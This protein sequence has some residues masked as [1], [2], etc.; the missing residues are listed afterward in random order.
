MSSPSSPQPE[1]SNHLNRVD[2]TGTS[3]NVVQ[4][5]DI[6]GGVHVHHH[7]DQAFVVVPSQL[8]GDVSAFVDRQ[9]ELAT[10]DA[11]FGGQDQEQRVPVVAV[12]TGTAGVGKTSLALRWA[13]S[14]RH[15]FP[16]GQL[17]VN[18][19]GYDP[20]APLT[21]GQV[22]IR[23]LRDLGVP[24]AA[25][26]ADLDAQAALFRSVLARRHV[27]VVLDNAA[28]VDQVRPLLPGTPTCLTIVTSRDRMSALVARDGAIRVAV[29]IL[30]EDDAV[31]LLDLMTSR[32][33][34]HDGRHDLVE[35]ARLCARL[36]L[37]LRLAA[38]R[39]A[40][41]PMLAL[42]ELIADL[43]DQ[44]GLWEALSPD[45]SEDS[46]AVRT[47]FAWSYRALSEPAAHMF[48]RLGLHPGNQF[49]AEAAAALAGHD[50]RTTRRH[51]DVLVGAHLLDQQAPRRYEFHDLLRAYAHDQASDV[52]DGPQRTEAVERVICWYL[53]AAAVVLRHLTGFDST[54]ITGS[55]PDELVSL[56]PSLA[57][58]DAAQH[59]YQAESENLVAAT[60]AAA[61]TGLHLLAWRLAAVVGRL[62]TTQNAFDDWMVTGRIGL[63]SALA[64]GDLDGQA[65]AHANLG[66]AYLQ[67]GDLVEADANHRKSLQI[68]RELGDRRGEVMSSNALGLTALRARRLNDAVLAFSDG[69]HLAVDLDDHYWIGNLEANLGQALLELQRYGEA[70]PALETALRTLR[71][72]GNP[73]GE[74]NALYLLARLRRETGD[75]ANAH[76]NIAAAITIAEDADNHMW[77]A[78]WL[79]ELGHIHR[80]AG[81]SGHALEAYQRSAALQRRLGD[82]IREAVAISAAGDVYKDLD[83]LDDAVS[84]YTVA[85]GTLH[86][87]RSPWHHACTLAGCADAYQKLGDLNGARTR[88]QEA[89]ALLESFN[90]PATTAMRDNLRGHTSDD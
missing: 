75:L 67:M 76:T 74:G 59:W 40:S 2:S 58:P 86:D 38:E 12:I 87:M 34:T 8:P 31:A 15:R 51:L 89:L 63:R 82:R 16:D 45:S 22:L 36:P 79:V 64:A 9:A 69:L 53:H 35:L 3:G 42:D 5:R 24:V 81:E 72:H 46:D 62:C 61:D 20:A 83:R 18:L 21:G 25:I 54:V 28:T 29:N 71:E 32:Y 41:R 49:S 13:H 37:A 7:E 84:F 30:A 73:F 60:R 27:L 90:D 65:W 39:A 23:F 6:H 55:V 80:A 26:P 17:Y 11:A 33:R 52:D 48:R 14:I 85:A 47:V 1:S 88:R 66:T 56:L 19:R 57:T 4:A 77:L 44:S 43:R 10:L 50:L 78:H 68:R 70:G